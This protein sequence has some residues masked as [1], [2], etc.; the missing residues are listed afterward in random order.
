[1]AERALAH[2]EKIAWRRAIEGAD[3]IEAIGVLGW[4]LI[5]KKG[6]FEVGDKCVFFEID[7]KL[8]EKEWSEFLRPKHFNIKTLKLNKF[9]VW[10][11]GLAIPISV[12]PEVP[13][14]TPEGTDVTELIGVKYSVVEDNI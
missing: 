11:Q 4:N 8:P 14:D 10:S 12:I 9:K 13:D 3:N 6:E 5:A 1:M 2:V 7:S